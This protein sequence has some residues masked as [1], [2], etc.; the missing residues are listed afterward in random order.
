MFETLT[1]EQKPLVPTEVSLQIP[2]PARPLPTGV[3]LS[4]VTAIA[5]F[6]GD[7]LEV[8][9]TSLETLWNTIADYGDMRVDEHLMSTYTNRDMILMRAAFDAARTNT[10]VTF[11][12]WRK[13][14]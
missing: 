2:M 8:K 1:A 3:L 10:T 6:S 11:D 13:T 14:A 7:D 12:E 9:A 4:I 5:A